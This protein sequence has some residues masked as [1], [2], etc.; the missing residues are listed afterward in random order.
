MRSLP[1]AGPFI[2]SRVR[3]SSLLL[4]SIACP[5]QGFAS[6]GRNLLH[7]SSKQVS[8][9]HHHLVSTSSSYLDNLGYNDFS[10]QSNGAH[11]F[12]TTPQ[13]SSSVTSNFAHVPVLSL[14]HADEIANRAI[15]CCRRNAFNPVSVS[16]LDAAGHTL[17]FKRMDGCSPV[18]I[19]DFAHAKAYS[20]VVNKY[21]SRVFRDRYTADEASAKFGQMLGMVSI[22]QGKMA[23]FPGGILLQLGDHLV[24]AVGVSGA[25]GDEDEY[26]AIRGVLEA[27]LGLTTVPAQHSCSTVKDAL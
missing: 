10:E 2:L 18:G 9:R 7:T 6:F 19:P 12:S 17:V 26:C 20:C 4:S 11:Y 3:V 24:G 21:P 5:A 1:I 27:N 23:P 15:E 25:A 13:S 8:Y 16:V 22:S 14:D